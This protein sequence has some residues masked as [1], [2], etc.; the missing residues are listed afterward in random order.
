MQTMNEASAK[1]LR[2]LGLAAKA[3]KLTIGTDLFCA[4]LARGGEHAPRLAVEAGDSSANTHKRVTDRCAY[5]GVRAVRLAA[6]AA[7]LAHA[8]GKKE[9]AVAVVGVTDPHLAAAIS[10]A[11]EETL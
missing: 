9:A 4:A 2:L 7:E 8:V 5:Y 6:T 11:F 1:T 10:A 3:G